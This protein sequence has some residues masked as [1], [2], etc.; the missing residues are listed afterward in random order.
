[1]VQVK[2]REDSSLQTGEYWN[3]DKEKIPIYLYCRDLDPFIR[4]DWYVTRGRGTVLLIK[5]W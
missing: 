3:S 1:M 2:L 5:R 4:V